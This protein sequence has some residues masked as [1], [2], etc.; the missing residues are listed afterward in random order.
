MRRDAQKSA[1]LWVAFGNQ[2][3]VSAWFAVWVLSR[4]S[5]PRPGRHAPVPTKTGPSGRL[6]AAS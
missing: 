4:L 2:P 1:E 6:G 3:G 5:E